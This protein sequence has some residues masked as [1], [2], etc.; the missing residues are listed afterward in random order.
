ML[1]DHDW[2]DDK[3]PAISELG[4]GLLLWIDSH[5]SMGPK[6]IC[7]GVRKELADVISNNLSIIFQWSWESEEV[8]VGSKLANVSVFKKGV[9]EEPGNYRSESVI[10]VSCKKHHHHQQQQK[11]P[12][13][14]NYCRSY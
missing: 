8:P 4:Q 10:S 3:L 13:P 1:E 2:R 7:P 11:N 12:N 6:G 14:N 5:K 9:R